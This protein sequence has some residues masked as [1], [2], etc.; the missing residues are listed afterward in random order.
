MLF[1]QNLDR[2]ESMPEVYTGGNHVYKVT[3]SV[4]GKPY[5][6]V[7]SNAALRLLPHPK[8]PERISMAGRMPTVNYIRQRR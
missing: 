1:G 6:T 8:L 4:A 5:D 2:S 7:Y 3:F